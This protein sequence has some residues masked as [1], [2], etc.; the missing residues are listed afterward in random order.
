[1]KK[2][3]LNTCCALVAVGL[4]Q[5]AQAQYTGGTLNT[6]AVNDMGGGSSTIGTPGSTSGA[7]DDYIGNGAGGNGSLTVQNGTLTVNADDFKIANW[8]G[9]G[10]P[11]PTGS[12]TVA[13]T[14]TLNIN[15]NGQWGG[16]VGQR[17][18]GTLTINGGA[19][20]WNIAGSKEQRLA[21]GNG[22]S[23]NGTLN[24]NGG[25]LSVSL[26][27]AANDGESQMRVGSDG[28]SGILNLNAG[29]LLD[30]MALPFFLGGKYT[31]L[32]RGTV[33]TSV[34][35]GSSGKINIL[36]G[37]FEMTGV[38]AALD[39]SKSTFRVGSLGGSAT[40]LINFQTGA[41]GALSL[42]GWQQSDFTSLATAGDLQVNGS[43]VSD[44]SQFTYSSVGGQGILTLA[45]V[46][47]PSVM[48]V[49]GC[50]LLS[51][52]SII[53]GKKN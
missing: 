45:A 51:L 49:F 53:R 48:A 17:G 11:P 19:V 30:S 31:G 3:L 52:V 24:L 16:G 4:A 1:M 35:A 18:T 44:L 27:I 13:S 9:V 50:G 2:I 15:N 38:Y 43:T 8:N 34:L 10:S 23:G 47:E 22:G 29:T 46:P 12:I 40:G 33:A 21:I 6:T 37:T 28:G 36:N 42:Y 26:G 32:N 5:S 39:A 20:S 41:T 25:S 7:Q 14:G